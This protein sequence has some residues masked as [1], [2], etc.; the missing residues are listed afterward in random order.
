MGRTN[1]VLDDR[2]IAKALKLSKVKTKRDVIDAAL[3]EFVEH[4]QRPDLRE[5]FGKGL[6]D[7]KYDYKRAR[8]GA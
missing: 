7:P 4:R 5:L 8:A 2:L 1:V 3:R 6:I